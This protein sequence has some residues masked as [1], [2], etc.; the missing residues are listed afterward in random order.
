MIHRRPPGLRPSLTVWRLASARGCGCSDAISDSRLELQ[1]AS[2]A[3]RAQV[4]RIRHCEVAGREQLLDAFPDG[5]R[6]RR[7]PIEPRDVGTD[8]SGQ[9]VGRFAEIGGEEVP[10]RSFFLPV[11]VGRKFL[12]GTGETSNLPETLRAA[13]LIF[14]SMA[15]RQASLTT[16][17]R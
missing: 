8:T 10:Q 13:R 14:P 11:C 9:C 15:G 16:L 1:L 17:G 12:V 3:G 5:C 4:G 7:E 2:Q 6:F